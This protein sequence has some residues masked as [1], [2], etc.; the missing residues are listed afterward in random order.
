MDKQ[1]LF[2]AVDGGA[3]HCRARIADAAGACLGSGHA[4]PA[5]TRLGIEP[6][7]A[8]ILSA[9][10]QALQAAGLD[11]RR[12]GDLHAG[13]GLA[14]LSLEADR[15]AVMAHRHPFLSLTAETDAYTACL[16]A[17]RGADGGIV[18]LGTGSNACAI[19]EG[20]IIDLGGWG[21]R[22]GDQGSAAQVGLAALRRALLACEGML[23]GSELCR[24]LLDRFDGEPEQA[25]LWAEAARPSD[26][27]ALA[28]LVT[29]H[30]TRGDTVA[31]ALMREAGAEAALLIAALYDRGVGRIALVGGFARHIRPW[32]PEA[33]LAPLVEPQGDGLDGALI[34]ARRALQRMQAAADAG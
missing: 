12:I 21:F 7:F 8:E 1:T 23:P 9:T 6:V 29:E 2:L 13:L 15:R 27:G 25:V 26:Y 30:A 31:E 34:L 10:G 17:H 28:Q 20:T 18:T 22:L 33:V 5:N 32:L 24:S 3:T 4:G 14:G 11:S 19:V 16:G